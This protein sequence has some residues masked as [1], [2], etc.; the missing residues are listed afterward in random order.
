MKFYNDVIQQINVRLWLDT[1][2]APSERYAYQQ[3]CQKLYIFRDIYM[4]LKRCV[5]MNTC[6]RTYIYRYTYIRIY[7]NISIHTYI[8]TYIYIHTYIHTH[9]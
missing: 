9:R 3:I 4:L 1:H 5:Y 8:D 7:I 6:I 2:T